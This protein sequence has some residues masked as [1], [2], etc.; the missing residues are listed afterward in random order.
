MKSRIR[1]IIVLLA[2]WF[3]IAPQYSHAATSTA[4]SLALKLPVAAENGAGYKRAAFTL[5]IDADHDGCDTRQEVLIAES[6]VKPTIES[7]CK[8]TAG[9]WIS[10]YDNKTWTKPADVDID[11]V[12]PLKEAWDSG[13]RVWTKANRTRYANDLDFSWSLDAV[14]DNVNSSKGDRDPADWLPPLTSTHC[15]YAIHWVAVKYR[16]RLNT[17]SREQKKLLSI[18]SGTC[19]SLIITIP[20]RAI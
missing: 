20:A 15:S 3:L 2:A 1:T 4:R 18:L 16:W 8:I 14:T 7:K 17:D 19:G 6:K 9:K 5:W 10:W 12:V 13:A 11:H